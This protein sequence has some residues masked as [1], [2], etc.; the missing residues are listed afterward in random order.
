MSNTL[1]EIDSRAQRD[2][3]WIIREHKYLQEYLS[4]T[5]VDMQ[6]FEGWHNYACI[7]GLPLFDYPITPE[8]FE[9]IRSLQPQQEEVKRRG[10]PKGTAGSEAE[11]ITEEEKEAQEAERIENARESIRQEA[12]YQEAVAKGWLVGFKW[13]NAAPISLKYWLQKYGIV[14]KEGGPGGRW[15]WRSVDK[16]FCWKDGKP[17]PK[18]NIKCMK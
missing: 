5:P 9:Y 17:I 3:D 8:E 15:C 14:Q 2:T 7:I 18:E 4:K 13:T 1:N 6:T 16:V 11:S 10:R 12:A